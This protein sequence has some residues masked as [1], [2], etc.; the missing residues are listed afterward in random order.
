MKKTSPAGHR[1]RWLYFETFFAENDSDGKL[2]ENWIP[3]FDTGNPMPFRV[4]P[5]SGTEF[6]ASAAKQSK[7]THRL[8]GSYRTGF[9]SGAK[10]RATDR[11]N[12]Q[13][14]NIEAVLPD[15]DSGIR[16]LTLLASSGVSLAGN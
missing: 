11:A 9:E 6:I 3:A 1:R 7:V 12:G 14:F 2:V 10:M 4:E 15:R 13:I 16:Y 8:T 5:L